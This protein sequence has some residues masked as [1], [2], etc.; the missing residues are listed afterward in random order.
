LWGDEA[1]VR[2]RFN[3]AIAEMRLTR[4]T[5]RMRFPFD[6]A[7]TVEFFRRYYGPTLRAF[8]ALDSAGQAVLMRDLVELQTRHNVSSAANETDT[9][10]EYLEVQARLAAAD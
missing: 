9:P 1:V 8:A 4:Q 5:A 10:A 3:G 6:P 7:A 2:S